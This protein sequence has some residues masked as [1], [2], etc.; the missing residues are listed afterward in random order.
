MVVASNVALTEACGGERQT[1]NNRMELTA[2]LHALEYCQTHRDDVKTVTLYSD[3]NLCVQTYNSWMEGWKRRGWRRSRGAVENLDLVKQLD[4]LK[5]ACPFVNL[6]W[7]KAHNGTKWN[8][9]ADRLTHEGRRHG[10]AAG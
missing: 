7:I 9:Y 4:T 3:S 1:T 5:Q 8:E 10:K 2:I 6:Q